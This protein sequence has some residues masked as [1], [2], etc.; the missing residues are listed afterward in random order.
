MLTLNP[1]FPAILRVSLPVILRSS[2]PVI[3]RERSDRRNPPRV[4]SMGRKSSHAIPRKI[5]NIAG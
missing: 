1:T 4:G 2:P 3:L 5:V